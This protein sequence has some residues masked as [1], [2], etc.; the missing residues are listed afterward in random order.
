MPIRMLRDWTDS[1]AV[2]SLDEGAETLFTR[3]IMKA[4]DFGRFT[5]N[6]K[7][8]RSLC[9]PLKDGIRESDIARRI[10]ACETAGL[11][12]TYTASDGKPLLEIRNFGQRMRH[13]MK[14]KYEGPGESAATSGNPRRPAADRGDQR[15]ACGDSPPNGREVETEEK[16]RIENIYT[17]RATFLTSETSDGF[18]SFMAAYPRRTKPDRA[19]EVWQAKV[20]QLVDRLKKP[21]AEIEAIITNAAIAYAA[22]PAGREPEPGQPEFRPDPH[23]WLLSGCYAEDPKEW[24]IPNGTTGGN[25]RKRGSA[26]QDVSSLEKYFAERGLGSDQK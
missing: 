14:A 10:A 3:L 22:S 23:N 5:A 26:K 24:Q 18:K 6:P 17:D 2:N 21:D 20:W 19:W 13:G 1:E 8:I 4:D 9:Y 25:S 7:L 12:A 11:I 15:P 16:R